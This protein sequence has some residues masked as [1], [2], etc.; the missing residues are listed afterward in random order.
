M[1]LNRGIIYHEV[2]VTDVVPSK[3]LK[4][5]EYET[6]FDSIQLNGGILVKNKAVSLDPYMRGRMRDPAIQSYAA[7][8]TLGKPIDGFIVGEVIRS[9]STEYPVSSFVYAFASVE[10]YSLIDGPR[11][12]LLAR[13]IENKEGLPFSSLVGALGLSGQTAWWSFY[14]IGKPKKGE[15]IFVTAAAGA[16]GQIVVQLAKREGLK[17]IGSAGSDDKVAFL[18]ELGADIAFNY[19][20]ENTLE[21]LKRNPID[22]Y[23]DN[24]GGE[25]LDNALETIN[26]FGRIIACG[27]VSQYNLPADQKYHLKN[28]PVI[29]AKEITYQGFIMLG[30]DLTEFFATL[31]GLIASGEIRLREHITKG[32]DNGEAFVAMMAGQAEGKAVMSLE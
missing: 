22:I 27:V 5:E 11:L 19:K 1:V 4:L 13:R 12:A 23:F 28:W 14:N 8:Y 31:P 3:H 25:V 18:K 2:P 26:K 30:K 32:L 24:V 16:V 10:Q 20:K 15:T 6:D 21:I 17:V 7:A 9:E 29:V